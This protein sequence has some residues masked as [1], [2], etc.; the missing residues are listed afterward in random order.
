M[1]ITRILLLSLLFAAPASGQEPFDWYGR[2]PYRAAVPRP[3]SL[4]G[5]ALGTRHTMYHEQQRAL[6]AMIAAAADR[7]RTEVTGVTAEG[8]ILRVLIISA[9]ENI[10]R[11]DAIRDDLQALA[12][13]RR[14]ARAD[15]SVLATRAPAVALLSHSIHGNE[16]AGFEASMQTVYQLLASDEPATLEI[17]R[18]VVTIIN[19]TQN[20]DGHERFA[21]WNNSVAVAT[22]EPGA[23]EQTEPWSIHGRTNHYRFDMNRDFMAQSQIETRALLSVM[24]RWKPQLVVDLHST[25]DQFFFP[26][27]S[28]PLNRNI[29]EWQRKWEARFGAGNASAFDRFGWQYYV[30]DIFDFFYPGYVDLFPSLSGATGMTFE[31]DGGPELRLRKS[32]GTVMTFADGIAHHFVAS[33]AT[34]E[35]LAAGK[36]E[37][38]RDF[39]EFHATGLE[40]VARRPFKRVVLPP[41]GDPAR[42]LELVRDL[43]RAGV[44]V[45]RTTQAFTAA[46]AHEYLEGAVSRREF[47]VGSYV[48]DLAQPQARLATALLEPRALVDS[49]FV[50]RQLGRF[51]RNRRRGESATR[52]GYEFYDIT[53]WALPHS[54]GVE[55]WWT[56]DTPAVTGEPVGEAGQLPAGGVSARA[57]SAYIFPAGHES[58]ARL[59][60]KLL[61]EKFT[62]G[63]AT[64]PLRADSQTWGTGT[65]VVRTQRNAA[66]LHERIAALAQEVGAQVRPLQTAYPDSGLGVGSETVM[67]LHAPRILLAGGPGVAQTTFGSLWFHIERELGIPVVPIE[68]SAFRRIDLSDYNVLILPD[69]S[70]AT[71]FR[72]LGDA[73]RLK[74]WVNEGGAII[75]IGGAI[76]MLARTELA[77]TTVKPVGAEEDE[78]EEEEKGDSARTDTAAVSVSARPGPPI[79]SPT[80]PG[81]DEPEDVPGIVAKGTLDRSHWLTY[82]YGRDH[83]PVPVSGAGFLRPSRE[84]DNPVTILGDD[85]VISGFTWPNNTARLLDRTVWAAVENVGNGKVILFAE[86]PLF[87]AFWRGPAGLFQNALLMGPGRD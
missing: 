11:L 74:R 83:L 59:A 38:L 77:L 76:E 81:P 33:L 24:T 62:V 7:V 65:Y 58:S 80:A 31:T 66:T 26:P 55:A 46:R 19:P 64:Q 8:R 51:E 4:L 20:P 68:L 84:G 42:A 75:A 61:G 56:E 32:D 57:R 15:V 35:V 12:D 47:A 36:E 22:D 85:A 54:H 53:A 67:P 1:R 10:A 34:L 9:P 21:A 49:A 27:T 71:M 44:E 79:I 14:T 13:P 37:R 28:D 18:N 41:T 39:H 2:G 63:V 17:L 40:Q 30:R 5:H 86:D 60:L 69:G 73:D 82:G 25:T 52:E 16:P 6:D 43:S 87:R 50:R 70:E 48:I 72:E 78:E 3:D 29:G 45:T 23:L